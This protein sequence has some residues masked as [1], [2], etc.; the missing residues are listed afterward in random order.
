MG[1]IRALHDSRTC[2]KSVSGMLW[3]YKMKQGSG[4]QRLSSHFSPAVSLR[5]DAGS[6]EDM[7]AWVFGGDPFTMPQ[8]TRQ[9]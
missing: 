6:R 2:I 4:P 1:A 9:F 8:P 5:E 7:V 3:L